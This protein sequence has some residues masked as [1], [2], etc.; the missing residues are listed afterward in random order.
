[1]QS[2]ITKA[3]TV[4]D[5]FRQPAL[6]YGS[7]REGFADALTTLLPSDNRRVLL[8]AFIGWSPREGSGVFDPIRQVGAEPYFYATN[9]DL[10]VDLAAFERAI[11]RFTP[12]VVVVI[13]YFGRTEPALA[14]IGEIAQR[15]Q[16]I[17]VEDLA[18]GLFSAARG[19]RAGR[20]GDFALYSL[21]KMFAMTTGGM[22]RYRDQSLITTQQ[23]N[24]PNLA[25]LI[26]D[27]D[28][29]GIAR[30]RRENFFAIAEHLSRSPVASAHVDQLW[31]LLDADDVPQTL[32]VRLR[33]IDRDAVYH[34]MNAEGFGMTS[35]YHTMIEEVHDAFP[36][37]MALARSIINFPVHQDML[38]E[39]AEG[40]IASFERAALAARR[41]P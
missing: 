19:G 7:A 14:A 2:S 22:V 13:H 29:N 23:G 25:A 24:A 17:L 40:M 18:H 9:S 30:R 33:E 1:M 4:T 3:A 26:A 16:A 27:Y 10:T 39:Q 35:L 12:R 38:P 15:H 6:Y 21:H 8:P 41:A 34:A 31:P 28:W 20:T 37:T 32:P 5:N 36:Q 11:T